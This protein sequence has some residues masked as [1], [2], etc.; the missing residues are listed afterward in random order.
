MGLLSIVIWTPII[1]GCALLAFSGERYGRFVRWAALGAAMLDFIFSLVLYKQFDNAQAGMQFVEKVSWIPSINI[2]Y[3]IGVDGLSIW[4]ILLNTFVTVLV[5]IACW[6]NIQDRIN[7]FMGA[8]LVLSGL[9]IA[10][11]TA[12]DALLFYIFFEATLVPMYVIIGIWG[13]PRKIYSAFKFFLYTFMGS[14]FMMVALAYLYTAAGQSFDIQTWHQLPLS[15]TE[16][17]LILFAFIAAF[18]VKLPMWPLHTW[19]PDVHVEAPTGGSAVLAA[20]MLKLAGYGFLRLALPIVPDAAQE[21]A[22]LMIVLSIIAIIYIGLVAIVQTD[23]KRLVAYSS[24]AHMGYVTLGIF[25]FTPEGIA[26]AMLMMIAH[27][28]ISAGMFLCVGVLYDRMHSRLIADY[29]GVVNVMPRFAAL[30]L[31][32]SFGNFGV[33][34]TA[35]LVAEWTVIIAAVEANLWV[36][37]LAATSLVLAAGYT[38]WMVQRVFLGPVAN[39]QVQQ[40][41][42]INPRETLVLAI[43]A[44]SVVAMGVYPK[45]ITDSM[46]ATIAQ[47]VQHVSTSKLSK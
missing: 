46:D 2:F 10:T 33:P 1:A 43:L 30:A 22:W 45:P 44:L 12:L 24:V 25:L 16:Q 7:Q 39:E 3:H 40:L 13:G 31:I 18:G 5:V 34:G 17:T 36:G 38:L 19:L 11:F 29:G 41:K 35:G 42:E 21:W 26:G 9:L 37:L 28:V 14:L 27:G 47:L 4:L 6:E 32:F 8:L 23:M 15:A 20:I